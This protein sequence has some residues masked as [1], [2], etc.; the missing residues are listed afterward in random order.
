MRLELNIPNS[1]FRCRYKHRRS[2]RYVS[3]K[4]SENAQQRAAI[5]PP[6]SGS[7]TATAAADALV[8]SDAAKSGATDCGFPSSGRQLRRAGGEVA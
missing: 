8:T 6:T 1:R 4:A 5:T 2:M 3:P 7:I